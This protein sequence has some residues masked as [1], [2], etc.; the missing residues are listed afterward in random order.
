MS[1]DAPKSP[2]QPP[3]ADDAHTAGGAPT[4]QAHEDDGDGS[5]T[6]SVPAGLSLKQLREVAESDKTTESGTS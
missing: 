2:P 6:G 4:D 3:L 1:D 5:L